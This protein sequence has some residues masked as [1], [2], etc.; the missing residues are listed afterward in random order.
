M[1]TGAG[2]RLIGVLVFKKAYKYRMVYSI[3]YIHIHLYTHA[4]LEKNR[5]SNCFE[6]QRIYFP[7]VY[8]DIHTRINS[9]MF[10]GGVSL[11]VKNLGN[12]LTN[13]TIVSSTEYNNNG[14]KLS[15]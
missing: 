6:T 15:Y 7:H 2:L 3:G 1:G 14:L 4:L 9:K 12:P 13:T 5:N 10:E 8:V 11:L